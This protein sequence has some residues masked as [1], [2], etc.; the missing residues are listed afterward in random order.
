[1]RDYRYD[2]VHLRSPDPNATATTQTQSCSFKAEG[3]VASKTNGLEPRIRQTEQH[4]GK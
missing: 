4:V 1:M 3:K 2:H